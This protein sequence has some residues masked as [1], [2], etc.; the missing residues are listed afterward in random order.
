MDVGRRAT[1]VGEIRSS[2]RR[3]EAALIQDATLADLQRDHIALQRAHAALQRHVH[4]L[5]TQARTAADT[6]NAF[7]IHCQGKYVETTT[8]LQR[9]GMEISSLTQTAARL[10]TE[11]RELDE[12]R[13]RYEQRQTENLSILQELRNK[14]VQLRPRSLPVMEAS[15]SG[16]SREL[17]SRLDLVRGERDRAQHDLAVTCADLV[18][19]L[20]RHRDLVTSDATL[21]AAANMSRDQVETLGRR[22][23]SLRQDTTQ[24]VEQLREKLNDSERLTARFRGEC[25]TVRLQF[26]TPQRDL[27]IARQ[28]RSLAEAQRTRAQNAAQ[29][30]ESRIQSL[31]ARVSNLE[32]DKTSFR[33]L[34][35]SHEIS[36]KTLAD[37][38]ADHNELQRE[39]DG[40]RQKHQTLR[41]E[42]KAVRAERDRLVEDVHRSHTALQVIAAAL[43]PQEPGI[44]PISGPTAATVVTNSR[45]AP[46]QAPRPMRNTTATASGA[47]TKSD[48]LRPSTAKRRLSTTP[49]SRRSAKISRTTPP[50][51]A[52]RSVGSR[53][54]LDISHGAAGVINCGQAPS[55]PRASG[56]SSIARHTGSSSS[57]SSDHDSLASVNSDDI[58]AAISGSR[59]VHRRRSLDDSQS[60]RPTSQARGSG[61][62][63]ASHPI[64]VGGSGILDDSS[65]GEASSGG[66]KS[67][68][69]DS[70][71]A[72]DEASRGRASVEA[73]ATTNTATADRDTQDE[74]FGLHPTRVPRCQWIPGTFEPRRFQ[75]GEVDP[76]KADT[77]SALT[78]LDLT[79]QLLLKNMPVKPAWLFKKRHPAPSRYAKELIT[80]AQIDALLEAQPWQ[81]LT[82]RPDPLS[83][84]PQDMPA[85]LFELYTDLES[86]Y[87]QEYWESTHFLQISKADWEND[88]RV[89]EYYKDRKK[90]RT[91]AGQEWRAF[92]E[93]IATGIGNGLFDL[94][95]LLDPFFLQFPSRQEEKHWYPVIH[96]GSPSLLKSL[97]RLDEAEPWRNQYRTSHEDHPARDISRLQHK[98]LTRI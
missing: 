49:P 17:A 80:G 55:T 93:V 72:P 84:N 92:L 6:A 47:S 88:A 10:Q 2:L 34:K 50:A 63:S 75:T 25:E 12:V 23:Q 57:S 37:L 22:I 68:Q 96:I 90:R 79:A 94:D 30:Y 87:L 42:L 9:A 46:R 67:H 89:L 60:G 95:I 52:P 48:Q 27:V 97:T 36:E 35:R 31:R 19:L 86:K 81:A 8:E 56:G 64:D 59:S 74:E 26:E 62:G 1:D 13:I 5:H 53:S 20:Q 73:S 58:R 32:G 78:C 77:V 33:D 82:D 85:G 43:P 83:F 14:I 24:L 16:R 98:F 71:H 21:A 45:S 40:L 39:R 66:S 61:P 51:S 54:A 65:D 7:V 44:V 38:K 4:D 3:I 69:N 41:C 11:V 91:T 70:D 18:H 15:D 28:A 76:W 29:D